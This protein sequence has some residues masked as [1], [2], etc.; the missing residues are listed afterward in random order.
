M[1]EPQSG[2]GQHC[3][4]NHEEELQISRPCNGQ[5]FN[6]YQTQEY[7][8]WCNVPQQI[9]LKCTN[10]ESCSRVEDWTNERCT[11]AMGGPSTVKRNTINDGEL[12]TFEDIILTSSNRED[13][14]NVCCTKLSEVQS[15]TQI[16]D[17]VNYG[18]VNNILEEVA[19]GGR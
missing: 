10:N 13:D 15:N 6:E 12:N 1:D 2:N 19:T 8:E 3:E 9:T 4:Y 5:E 7:P 16:V 11:E 17:D 14:Y 18:R